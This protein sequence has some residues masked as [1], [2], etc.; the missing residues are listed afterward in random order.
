MQKEPGRGWSS[1]GWFT[2]P[3]P[4]Q[5][6]SPEFGQ[7]SAPG[8]VPIPSPSPSSHQGTSSGV[9]RGIGKQKFG[10]ILNAVSYYGVGLPLGAVLLFVARIGVIGTDPG[11]AALPRS[12]EGTRLPPA[13]LMAHHNPPTW[14]CLPT[15]LGTGHTGVDWDG[16]CNY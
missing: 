6:Q 7:C 11:R 2:S 4:R 15:W 9:L 12:P 13:P 14:L 1:P 5:Q 10:A 8:P 16:P 3:P